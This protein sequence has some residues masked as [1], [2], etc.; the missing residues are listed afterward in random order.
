MRF[1]KYAATNLY[2]SGHHISCTTLNR[3]AEAT[4]GHYAQSVS[5]F[6][7]ALGKALEYFSF[8]NYNNFSPRETS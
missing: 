5:C 7:H 8:C 3:Q 6:I 4:V 2:V 1:T